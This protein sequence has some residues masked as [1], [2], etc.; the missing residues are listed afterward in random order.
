MYD[1][2]TK[3]TV[4]NPIKRYSFGQDDEPKKNVDGSITIYLQATGPGR[5]YESN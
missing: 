4:E 3:L 2:T 1:L 5:D